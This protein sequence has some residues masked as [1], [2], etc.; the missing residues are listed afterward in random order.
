MLTMLAFPTIASAQDNQPPGL[1]AVDFGD[2]DVPEFETDD[3]NVVEEEEDDDIGSPPSLEIDTGT[4][5]PEPPVITIDPSTPDPDPVDP[6]PNPSP[7]ELPTTGSPALLLSFL[8][9]L[10]YSITKKLNK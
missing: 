2:E 1:P 4:D 9:A 5:D 6:T 3:T 10:G 7:D 8:P